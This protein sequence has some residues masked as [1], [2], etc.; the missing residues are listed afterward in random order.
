MQIWSLQI[1]KYECWAYVSTKMRNVYSN[2][3]WMF[4][5][6]GVVCVMLCFGVICNRL[7][8]FAMSDVVLR[9]FPT[10]I[11]AITSTY[12]NPMS[13]HNRNF[14]HLSFTDDII[15]NNRVST[16]S[17]MIVNFLVCLQVASTRLRVV[18][19]LK[20][21]V[22]CHNSQAMHFCQNHKISLFKN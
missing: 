8:G 18:F 3:P 9:K 4:V 20:K 21:E 2:E 7:L 11:G 5:C 15:H 12:K 14:C 6:P 22:A 19:W 1:C 10:S 16:Q 17:W 13:R